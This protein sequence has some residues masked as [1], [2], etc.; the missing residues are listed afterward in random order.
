MALIKADKI[1]CLDKLLP[2]IRT[3]AKRIALQERQNNKQPIETNLIVQNMTTPDFGDS[4]LNRIALSEACKKV[5]SSFPLYYRRI[6][7][8]RYRYGLP[9]SMIAKELDISEGAARQANS[10][11]IKKLRVYFSECQEE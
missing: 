7:E 6:I 8:L 5:L 1:R 10:R 11:V 9:Y 3:V 2:W 4:I